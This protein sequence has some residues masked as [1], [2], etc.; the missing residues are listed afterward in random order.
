MGWQKG[1]R[2]DQMLR[3][4]CWYFISMVFII[5][6]HSAVTVHDEQADMQENGHDKG[7]HQSYH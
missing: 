1:D 2:L 4:W 5:C 3:I 7:V 6:L